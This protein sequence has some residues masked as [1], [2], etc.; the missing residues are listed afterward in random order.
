MLLVPLSVKPAQTLTIQLSNQACTITVRQRSTGLFIDLF[1][2]DAPIITSVICQNRNRIVRDAYLGFIGDLAFF[3]TQ[4][5]DDPVW[6]GLGA[7]WVLGYLTPGDLAA[8]GL[9]A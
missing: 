7:R 3:D 1:V 9:T 5:T 8:D 2:N 6:T 4:G